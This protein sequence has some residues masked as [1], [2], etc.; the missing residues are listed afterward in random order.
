VAVPAIL[1]EEVWQRAAERLATNQQFAGRNNKKHVYPLRGLLV[2]GTCGYTLIGRTSRESVSYY[3]PSKKQGQP[4]MPAHRCSIPQSVILPRV[5]QALS[6]LLRHPAL[7]ADAWRKQDET[8]TAA[9]EEADR[10]Q[11]RLRA[12]ERQWLRILD[13]FQSELLDKTQLAERKARLDQER[14]TLEQR[15]AQLTRLARREQAK[16]QMLEDFA[17]F[18]HEIE[19]A[20]DAPTPEVQQDVL[21][22]LIDHVVVER[23]AIVI[24]HIIPTDD[25]CRLLSGHRTTRNPAKVTKRSRRGPVERSEGVPPAAR[26]A[27]RRRALRAHGRRD[28]FRAFSGCFRV[29]RG[30]GARCTPRKTLD[31][32]RRAP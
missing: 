13:A 17:N 16:T 12:L 24:K 25:D 31:P 15:L 22:L 27:C 3:C 18:C 23:D 20:L 32:A 14:Q 21:R 9:P 5:W 6:D 4:G 7:L 26:P 2:C 10:L 28:R 8:T 19:G 1:S 30:P 11:A 29:F